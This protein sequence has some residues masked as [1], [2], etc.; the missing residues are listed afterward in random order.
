M[1]YIKKYGALAGCSNLLISRCI[2]DTPIELRALHCIDFSRNKF[3]YHEDQWYEDIKGLE[4]ANKIIKKMRT[5]FAI[6]DSIPLD[7]RIKNIEEILVL[8]KGT[9]KIIGYLKDTLAEENNKQK[10]IANKKKS[11]K[12]P[13]K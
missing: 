2:D 1:A 10:K 7:T 4:I 13:K 12:T 8:E 5:K 3:M 11:K 9:K 6:D